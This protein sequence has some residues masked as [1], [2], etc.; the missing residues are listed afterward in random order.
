ML[1]WCWS[2]VLLSWLFAEAEAAL[3]AVL[4]T[5]ELFFGL[6]A[7]FEEEVIADEEPTETSAGEVSLGT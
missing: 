4:N 5:E 2:Y 1:Y 3:A 6:T 7:F